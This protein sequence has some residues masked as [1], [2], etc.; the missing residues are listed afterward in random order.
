MLTSCQ[1]LFP[2]DRLYHVPLPTNLQALASP[3]YP[4]VKRVS[5]TAPADGKFQDWG[6]AETLLL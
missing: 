2:K 5:I 4:G 1:R 6:R 3:P